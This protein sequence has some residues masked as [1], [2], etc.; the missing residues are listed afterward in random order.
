MYSFIAKGIGTIRNARKVSFDPTLYH[1]Y[2][3]IQIVQRLQ[4]VSCSYRLPGKK[5]NIYGVLGLAD[6]PEQ[7]TQVQS[8]ARKRQTSLKQ[9]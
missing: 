3:R 8:V 7:S 1:V 4:C 5:Y 6:F 2:I 9:G